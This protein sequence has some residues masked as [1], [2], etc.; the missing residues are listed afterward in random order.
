MTW[1]TLAE[2]LESALA[3]MLVD[4]E[5]GVD[6]PSAALKR[7]GT[8]APAKFQGDVLSSTPLV[9]EGYASRHRHTGAIGPKVAKGSP[10]RPVCLCLVV[11]NGLG[12]GRRQEEGTSAADPRNNQGGGRVRRFLKLVHASTG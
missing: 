7:T 10:A 1:K 5:E 3:S 2:S 6:A 9:Q 11:D 4:G 8:K 12:G